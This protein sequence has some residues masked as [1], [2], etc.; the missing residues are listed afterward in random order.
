MKKAANIETD[1]ENCFLLSFG[2]SIHMLLSEFLWKIKSLDV[3]IYISLHDW[4]KRNVKKANMEKRQKELKC[5]FK[6]TNM[7]YLY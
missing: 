7:H 1:K 2:T 4:S 3:N 5:Q 6:F